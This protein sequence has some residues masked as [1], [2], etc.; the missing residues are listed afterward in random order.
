MDLAPSRTARWDWCRPTASTSRPSARRTDRRTV[1][2]AALCPCGKPVGHANHCGSCCGGCGVA[3][4]HERMATVEHLRRCPVCDARFSLG[5]DGFTRLV[6]PRYTSGPT[7]TEREA[8]P[9]YCYPCA[10]G[11][12]NEH[13]TNAWEPD[14]PCECPP[15]AIPYQHGPHLIDD[16]RLQ[17]QCPGGPRRMRP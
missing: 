12:H 14:I 5:P 1:G 4:E 3:T 7:A 17:I 10:R 2:D 13:K 8:S 15:C 9:F 6:T 11:D 16:G